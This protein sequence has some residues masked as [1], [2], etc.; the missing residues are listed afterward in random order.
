MSVTRTQTQGDVWNR[1]GDERLSV[2]YVPL[3]CCFFFRRVKLTASSFLN[4][5]FT[6]NISKFNQLLLEAKRSYKHDAE[7]RINI[8]VADT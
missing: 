4:R 7:G 2:T 1:N 8:Y 5:M 3:I 6:R